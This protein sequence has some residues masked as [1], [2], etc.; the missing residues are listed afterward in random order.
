[1]EKGINPDIVWTAA[2]EDNNNPV[3]IWAGKSYDQRDSA[4]FKVMQNGD[5]YAK[6]AILEGILYGRVDS[7]CVNIDQKQLPIV[8]DTSIPN[9]EYIRMNDLV[10]LFDVDIIF[11]NET[12]RMFNI[13]K[14]L[15]EA[16]FSGTHFVL[17]GSNTTVHYETGSGV[18]GGLNFINSESEAR[19]VVRHSKDPIRSSTLIFDAQGSRSSESDFT[20]TRKNYSEDVSVLVEGLLKV[21]KDLKSTSHNIEMRSVPNEGWGFY[22]G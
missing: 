3:R 7:G 5:V 6:N 8:D 12:D 15:R 11:G 17:E 1:M 18:Y 19:H 16:K 14:E 21:K 13:N 4:P 22:A 9:K 10:A 2:P 20:F